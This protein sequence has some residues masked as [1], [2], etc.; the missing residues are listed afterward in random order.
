M[1]KV[2]YEEMKDFLQNS[3][4]NVTFTK[5]DG[6]VRVMKC[7]LM[8]EHLPPVEVKESKEGETERKVNTEVLAVWDLDNEGWRSF[9]L[10][11]IQNF[12]VVPS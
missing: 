6:T 11:S 4:S 5:K 7:T 9:R 10:D 12:D 8:P 3:V 2:T 1:S